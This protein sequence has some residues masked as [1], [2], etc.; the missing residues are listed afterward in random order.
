MSTAS[1]HIRILS[2]DPIN[3]GLGFVVLEGPECLID[4]GVVHARTD[5]H[6]RCL[7]R[8]E[9]LMERYQP[10]TVVIEDTR[11]GSRRGKRV[12]RL[13]S[14][15]VMLSAKRHVKLRRVSRSQVVRSF[16]PLGG[17]TKHRIAEIV[18]TRFPEL[19][20]QLPA[21]RKPWQSESETMA[22]FD[23]VAFALAIPRRPK[24]AR[25]LSV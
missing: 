19:R 12:Q 2:L 7:E 4:W 8:V 5:K 13:L 10:R 20:A 3:R 14:S 11:Q 21:Q 25:Q 6:R 1:T 24:P 16:S 22:I 17:S 9:K 15:V 23:A 18:A